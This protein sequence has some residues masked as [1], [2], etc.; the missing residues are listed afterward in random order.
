LYEPLLS[1]CAKVVV[2]PANDAA[3]SN[4]VETTKG[5]SVLMV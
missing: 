5:Y 3:A 2:H 1:V 4:L